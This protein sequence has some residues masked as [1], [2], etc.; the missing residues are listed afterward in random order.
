MQSS[1]FGTSKRF[2][3]RT[4]LDRT[5]PKITHPNQI[6]CSIATLPAFALAVL[7]HGFSFLKFRCILIIPTVYSEEMSKG[8]VDKEVA[9]IAVASAQA[10]TAESDP[11]P[12]KTSDVPPNALTLSSQ[13]EQVPSVIEF[14]PVASPE[15]VVVSPRALPCP[16]ES[17]AVLSTK[18]AASAAITAEK[19]S[20][21]LPAASP[22]V[23]SPTA[24]TGKS[25][26]T[27]LLS[28]FISIFSPKASDKG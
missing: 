21:T 4:Q 25:E 8:S 5:P 28:G 18:Q 17:S 7:Q 3:E 9:A 2:E 16:D 1:I 26:S 24:A 20:P 14:P 13:V 11:P 10:V 12:S 15:S 22:V 19:L 6:P 27:G 23:I